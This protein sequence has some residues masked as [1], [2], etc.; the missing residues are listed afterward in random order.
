MYN[1]LIVEDD[2]S[3]NCGITLMLKKECINIQQ[4]YDLKTAT[5]IF[6]NNTLDLIIL[7]VN[8]PDGSG[9]EFCKNVRK[10]S[11]TP[12]IFLTANNLEVDIVTGFELGCDDY[13]TK[14]FSMMILRARVMAVLRRTIGSSDIRIELNNMVFDFDKMEFSKNGQTIHLKIYAFFWAGVR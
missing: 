10:S 13:I 9:I 2:I 1:I 3:L 4:A 14:P 8:L 7:D 5:L 12:I 11:N 6:K